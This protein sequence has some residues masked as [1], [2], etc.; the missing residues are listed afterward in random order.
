MSSKS[1]DKLPKYVFRTAFGVFRFKRNV[2][3]DIR[4]VSG[5]VFFY[6]V[7]GKEYKEAMRTYST[8][9]LEFDRFV[10]AYRNEAPVRDAALAIVSSEYGE[11]AMLQLAR[12]DVDENLDFALQDLAAKVEEDVKPEVASA[13]YSGVVPVAKTT[14]A[15]C[16][17]RHLEHKLSGDDDRDR[18]PKNMTDRCVRYCVEA[19]GQKAVYDAYV[20]DIT[21]QDANAIRDFLLARLKPSSV[22]RLFNVITASIT[23]VVSEDDLPIRN[24][25]S[26]MIIKNSGATK[27]DR[28]PLSKEDLYDLDKVFD[29][30]DDI[31]ALWATL[32]DTG[33]RLA[34]VVYLTVEDVNLQ[35]K[36]VAIR[37]NSLRG[38][39]KTTSSERTI[40]LSDKALEALQVLRQGKEA[41]EAIFTRYARPRG[42]D[43]AS[44]MLMKRLRKVVKDPKKTIHSLRHS[45]KDS[46]R[47]SGCPE[48]LAKSLLG[49]SDGSVASRYGSGYTLD[50]MREA[51]AKAW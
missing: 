43:A 44:Q 27:D 4:E 49:H 41:D 22:S 26:K 10:A 40:P 42:S 46:L 11:E 23:F 7:L 24:V 32:R 20:G 47:N 34:E 38:S 17:N 50:V 9:L 39:L 8:A 37:P 13:I 25:F 31:A 21:R 28:L 16:L 18:L 19:L 3:K 30:P 5:K 48:E 1:Q 6:K 33:A 45:M 12:G 29:A 35:D 15:D 14:L 2:P 36:S 51:L